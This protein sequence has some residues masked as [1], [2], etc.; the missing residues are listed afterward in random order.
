MKSE[1]DSRTICKHTNIAVSI[2]SDFVCIKIITFH[3]ANIVCLLWIL[4]YISNF[5][6]QQ[7]RIC[8][9][10]TS[11]NNILTYRVFLTQT[12]TQLNKINNKLMQL[13]IVFIPYLFIYSL[14]D[15]FRA[16]SA[17][18][19]GFFCLLYLQPPVICASARPW[20]CLVVNSTCF[21]R[22]PL[23]IRSCLQQDSATDGRKH[24]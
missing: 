6:H 3:V 2:L 1:R 13:L 5:S 16:T 15:M 18:H 20:H 8:Y 22:H 19:Q 21:E 17:H 7:R 24:R 14:L 4:S 23:I 10:C 12:Q 11:R 9:L